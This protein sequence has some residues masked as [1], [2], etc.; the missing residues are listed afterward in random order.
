MKNVLYVSSA[1]SENMFSYLESNRVSTGFV[2]GMPVAANKFHNLIMQGFIGNDS[3][4]TALVGLPVSFKSHKKKIWKKKKEVVDNV[5]F[6]NLPF[7]NLPFLKH[8]II[9][10][11]CFFNIL[12]WSKGKKDKLI[13]F[14]AA[15]VSI[16]PFIFLA[17]IFSK[18]KTI[19]IFSDIYNYMYDVE[20]K[21]TNYNLLGKISRRLMKHYYGKTYGYVFLSEQMNDLIN[22]NNKP[23]CVIEGVAST[24][25][26]NEKF[27]VS[28]SKKKILFYAGALRREYGLEILLD[29]FMKYK[30]NDVELWI[31]GAGDYLDKIKELSLKDKRIKYKGVV[32]NLEVIKMEH[33]ATLLINPRPSNLEFTQYSFPSKL[34]EYMSSGNSVLTTKLPTIPK[35]YYDYLFFIDDE[36]SD[37]IVD[38]LNKVLKKDDL[39]K[40][41][42][43]TKKFIED[44]KTEI[45]Q[46]KKIVN[47][48]GDLND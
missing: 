7:I 31:C 34:M 37:G 41:G 18:S 46:V 8:I 38:A 12:K 20:A 25:F 16:I 36:S 29:G 21:N 17:N 5:S 11:S 13:V 30:D 22:K 14:D 47:I 45:M 24:K 10:F 32:S 23:Y 40:Y 27:D 44:N 9:G 33:Q 43:K 26:L 15:F 4:V 6:I 1:C 19:A 42:L 28:K 35:D 3:T 48:C 39:K 2:Y